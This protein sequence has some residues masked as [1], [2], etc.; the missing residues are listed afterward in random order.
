MSWLSLCVQKKKK[1][2]TMMMN[3]NWMNT[4]KGEGKSWKR[5]L[6]PPSINEQYIIRGKTMPLLRNKNVMVRSFSCFQFYRS[7]GSLT[8]G[9]MRYC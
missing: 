7:Q 5:V 3:N 8:L 2:S 1:S 6:V 9:L 4:Y